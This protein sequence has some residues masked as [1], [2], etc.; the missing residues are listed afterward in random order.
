ML[1]WF[2]SAG[3]NCLIGPGDTGKSTVLDA[4]DL[5]LSARRNIAIADSDFYKLNVE[6]P[7]SITLTLG[8]LDDELLSLDAY[9]LFHRGMNPASGAIEDEPRRGL[10]TVLSLN[11][12]V[13]SDLEPV[14][15]LLSDRAAKQGAE[16]GLSWKDRQRLSAAVAIVL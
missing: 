4:I 10:E 9:G 1:D 6:H 3:I 11:L 13:Q 7:I 8:D 2:P 16:R 15:T 5:C 14:W 12:S